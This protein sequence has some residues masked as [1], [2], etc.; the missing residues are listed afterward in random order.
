VVV[1]RARGRV[2]RRLA[3]GSAHIARQGHRRVLRIGV[4]NRG[5][6]DEWIG[7]DRVRLS[8]WRSGRVVARPTLLA[9]RLLAR[10][11]GVMVAPL[12]SR[13]RGRYVL[14][15]RFLRPRPGTTVARRTYR[16]LL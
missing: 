2:A 8:L 16:L 4:V 15:V 13:L 12:R 14:E 3:L 1:V 7:R 6:L 11:R 10:S 5:D 9:R